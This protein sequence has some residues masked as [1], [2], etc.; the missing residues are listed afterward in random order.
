MCQ[1]RGTSSGD[2]LLGWVHK[3]QFEGEPDS[4]DVM[5]APIEERT[6]D[7][8]PVLSATCDIMSAHWLLRCCVAMV[9][10]EGC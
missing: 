10:A 6:V 1:G 3:Q 8:N 9:T 4:S 2:S 5:T 7:D